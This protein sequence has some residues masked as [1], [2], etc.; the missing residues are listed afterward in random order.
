MKETKVFYT[1]G[2]MRMRMTQA[3]D[4]MVISTMNS[5]MMIIHDLNLQT[6]AQDLKDFKPNMYRLMQISGKPLAAAVTHTKL[7]HAK[8]NRVEIIDDFPEKNE[9]EAISS[10]LLHPKGWVTVS[11]NVSADDNSEWCC[12]HDLHS[13]PAGSESDDEG[14]DSESRTFKQAEAERRARRQQMAATRQRSSP[15]TGIDQ[16]AEFVIGPSGGGGSSMDDGSEQRPSS[17][18]E[19]REQNEP[20]GADRTAGSS[21]N[22]S[23]SDDD[24][25]DEDIGEGAEDRDEPM[26]LNS[27]SRAVDLFSLFSHI[28]RSARGSGGGPAEAPSTGQNEAS[29]SRNG[30]IDG[31]S[32]SEEDPRVRHPANEPGGENHENNGRNVGEEGPEESADQPAAAQQR[33]RYQGFLLLPSLE[34]GGNASVMYFG[35]PGGGGG[36][37]IPAAAAGEHQVPEDAKLHHN[38]PRLTHYLEESNQGR[39]FIKEICFSGDGRVIGSP[40]GF[41]IRL[42]A[43]DGQCRDLSESASDLYI[44]N[45]S[46]SVVDYYPARS[47]PLHEVT[48][49]AGF[50]DDV[51]LSSAFSPHGYTLVT[52]CRSGKIAW[53]QPV[54]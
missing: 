12:V 47:R 48:C 45:R 35:P 7:F 15:L 40:Y 53:H 37:N 14:I 41:G 27:N 51:V 1:N 33:R 34:P 28:V 5:Y 25:D 43:F 4:K 20:D 19:N 50:H 17:S 3:C 46:S 30:S 13:Y 38:K 36:P 54:L 26:V 23:S 42:L 24:E 10:L 39:G 31:P 9:A 8:R 52:G 18:S 22:D 16:L 29:R 32:T 49:L 21:D 11:R 2:L 6:L 44:D